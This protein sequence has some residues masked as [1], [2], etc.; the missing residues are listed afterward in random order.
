MV[1]MMFDDELV[2]VDYNCISIFVNHKRHW[3]I[4]VFVITKDYQWF[5]LMMANDGLTDIGFIDGPQQPLL[6]SLV[7][8]YAL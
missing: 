8:R 7:I 3:Y 5:V 2:D 1:F 6:P 4:M